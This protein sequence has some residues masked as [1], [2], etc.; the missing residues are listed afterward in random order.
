MSLLPEQQ[1]ESYKSILISSVKSSGF[2]SLV[3]GATGIAAIVVGGGINLAFSALSDLSLWVLLAGSLLVLL[4]LILSPRAIA[5]FLIGRKGRY[6]TN[7]AIMTIA[8]FI[9]LLI[10]NIFMFGTSNRF[11]VTATRFFD[12]SEQTLQILDELDSEV[13]ATAF[14]VEY[15]GP[16]SARQQ[17]ERQ[18]AEDLLKE[19]SRRST[20]FS[21]RFVDPELNRAQ[22]LKYNVKVYPGVVFEDKN[23]GRQQGVSTFTEQEFVTGVLV[24]TDVQQKEVRFLTGHG[25]AEFT[26]DPMLRSVEDDGLDYAIEGMQRDNYRVLP[27]NLKQA[28]KVPEETAVLVIAGPTNNLDK[29]EFEAI[30]EFIAGGGNIVAMFDPGLPDG[31]NALIAP[32]GVVIGDKMVADAV[33]N[34]AGEMLTPMLQKANGQYSTSNQTGIG[35]AD[36]IGVTFYP[37]AGS[38]D[39]I[40][41]PADMPPHI[42]FNPIGVTTPASWLET[43][44]ENPGFSE[45]EFPGPFVI[46]GL[47]EASG[48]M[49]EPTSLVSDKVPAKIVIF[50]DSDFATNKYFHSSDNSDLFLNSVN[51]LADDYELISIRPKLVPYREL[52][53]NA[54]ERDFI[55]WSSWVFPPSLM[56]ILG[57]IVWWRRR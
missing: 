1:D 56:L 23:S 42:K 41:N 2:W 18:Q 15:Q 21:Y 39:S 31:F 35:I 36:K 14:F 49:Q 47:L 12:L 13:V 30:S 26:K 11:D 52:V 29:D 16:S 55:R 40:I 3:L 28:S 45:E 7:V 4:S 8:F 6:G 22:A 50:S 17:S 25:E 51:W 32:Y 57:V 44:P 19:F 27:L 43:D 5:I 54:R 33:S 34:V 38:I 46:S 48:Q 9:I 10:V 53:V 37:E 24:S 20:L